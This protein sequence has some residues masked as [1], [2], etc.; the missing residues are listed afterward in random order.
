MPEIFI[1]SLTVPHPHSMTLLLAAALFFCIQMLFTG[2]SIATY[3]VQEPA[4][5]EARSECVVLLHG[6]GRTRLSMMD[7]QQNLTRAGFHT[8]NLDY[9]STKKTIEG[10]AREDVPLAIDQCQHFKPSAI[11]FVTHSMGGIIMR[12]SLSESRPVNLGRMVMLSP[13]NRGAVVVDKLK[14]WWLFQWLNGPAGQQ[15]STGPDSVPN[16]LGPVDYPTGV[17]TGDRYAFFDAWFSSLIPGKDDGKVSV[18]R[19][20]VDGMADFLVVQKSHPF[21]MNAG[22]VQAETVYFLSNGIFKHQKDKPAPAEGR[23]WYS[24]P[25]N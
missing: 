10:I 22:Y 15:L 18:E 17:I 7:M 2:C 24:L 21:I 25:S 11:H 19:A 20:K 6:L 12:L 23:D 16:Q 8:V 1:V 9:P 4:A 3:S 5:E 14:D 13:P